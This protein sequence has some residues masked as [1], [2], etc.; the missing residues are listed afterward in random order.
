MSLNIN[1]KQ[2]YQTILGAI[3]SISFISLLILIVYNKVQILVNKSDI[4]TTIINSKSFG[5]LAIDLSAQNFMFAVSIQ[6]DDNQFSSNPY[7]IIKAEQKSY[8]YDKGVRNKNEPDAY[9]IQLEPCTIDHWKNLG[10]NFDWS[11]EFDRLVLDQWLCPVKNQIL[12]LQGDYTSQIFKFLKFSIYMCSQQLVQ[13]YSWNPQC[14]DQQTIANQL[15]KDGNFKVQFYHSNLIINADQSQNQFYLNSEIFFEFIPNTAYFESDIYFSQVSVSSDQSS[16]F[17]NNFEKNTYALHYPGDF[18]IKSLQNSN[19]PELSKFFIRR[20]LYDLQYQTTYKKF[21]DILAFSGGFI[22]LGVV[23]V[24]IL[25]FDC[26]QQLLDQ[27]KNAENQIQNQEKK[28]KKQNS[29]EIIVLNDSNQNCQKKNTFTQRQRIRATDSKNEQ[30]MK[31]EDQVGQNFCC[32]DKFSIKS[33]SFSLKYILN[34]IFCNKMCFRDEYKKA[35]S[36]LDQIESELDIVWILSQIKFVPLLIQGLVNLSYRTKSLE[37]IIKDQKSKCSP[38]SEPNKISQAQKNV[39]NQ[40]AFQVCDEIHLEPINSKNDVNPTTIYTENDEEKI[41]V[42]KDSYQ[43]KQ[44]LAIYNY[45]NIE[46]NDKKQ[47]NSANQEELVIDDD[48][49]SELKSCQGNTQKQNIDS[50][51]DHTQLR[52]QRKTNSSKQENKSEKSNFYFKKVQ[53]LDIQNYV[54]KPKNKTMIETPF[55]IGVNVNEQ[56]MQEGG[57]QKSQSINNVKKAANGSNVSIKVIEE[58][59]DNQSI[60][61]T[62][63]LQSSNIQPNLKQSTQQSISPQV[64][65]KLNQ[66]E[67]KLISFGQGQEEYS[68]QYDNLIEDQDKQQKNNYSEIQTF[69]L[70]EEK[71]QKIDYSQDFAQNNEFQYQNNQEKQQNEK[72]Q[73]NLNEELIQFDVLE[74]ENQLQDQNKILEDSPIKTFNE[75]DKQ[76]IIQIYNLQFEQDEGQFDYTPKKLFVCQNLE[77]YQSNNNEEN[78][79][80]NQADTHNQFKTMKRRTNQKLDTLIEQR[81]EYSEYS[82][83]QNQRQQSFNQYDQ[84][85]YNQKSNH[86]SNKEIDVI[87]DDE[88]IEVKFKELNLNNIEIQQFRN[89][90]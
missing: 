37:Q 80:Q 31:N 39:Q 54:L 14:A 30:K 57:R 26:S 56:N 55:N 9:Q 86:H 13:D 58:N 49:I 19:Q 18:N 53:V 59:E 50:N 6:Q 82:Y 78:H 51:Q 66:Q 17:Q 35:Q 32:F 52:E 12:H 65:N 69:Q 81:E 46:E 33:L 42:K 83:Q 68:V 79:Q 74:G 5:D 10:G 87:V 28:S 36:N 4:Q 63:F 7:F 61:H 76:E 73:N 20:N 8:L 27:N 85:T 23:L 67:D 47:L 34:N 72:R 48:D 38:I 88:K 24:A 29:F 45:D 64:N 60:L 75:L 62:Y 1:K 84:N 2:S 11:S 3:F 89:D 21:Y 25:S 16:F 90:S 44:V 15:S 43:N 71:G 22:Y 40:D 70:S 77:N 41:L